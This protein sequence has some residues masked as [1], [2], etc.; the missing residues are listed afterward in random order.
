MIDKERILV[1]TADVVL[2]LAVAAQYG[3]R[4]NKIRLQKLIYLA[5]AV[6]SLFALL[7]PEESHTT[8]MHGP[9]DSAIQRAADALAFRGF[10]TIYSIRPHAGGVSADYGLSE[11][12]LQLASRFKTDLVGQAEVYTEVAA[13]V[14]QIGWPR[15]RALAYAEPTFVDARARGYGRPLEV[16]DGLT[17]SSALVLSVIDNVLDRESL[18]YRPPRHVILDLFFRYLTEYALHSTAEPDEE[19]E[20]EGR[21]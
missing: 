8:Y 6:S 4:L 15:L 18:D 5:D 19:P 20:E 11:A 17:N 14:N 7:P 12:G 10:V 13:R 16:A 2:S 3:Q 1:R 9:Y 21:E